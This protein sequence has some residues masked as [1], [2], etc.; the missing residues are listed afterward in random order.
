[1]FYISADM[2]DTLEEALHSQ[3]NYYSARITQFA[4][5]Y[6]Y[7][8]SLLISNIMSAADFIPIILLSWL[9]SAQYIVGQMIR[10]NEIHML[11]DRFN[12]IKNRFLA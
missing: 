12:Q 3:I 2:R 8:V 1:M 10:S 6:L 5:M 7:L 4:A 11:R 9:T